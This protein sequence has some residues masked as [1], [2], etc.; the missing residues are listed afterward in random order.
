MSLY[1]IK[2]G[3]E[4]RFARSFGCVIE[5]NGSR[6]AEVGFLNPSKMFNDYDRPRDVEITS[7]FSDDFMDD[8]SFTMLKNHLIAC[9]PMQIGYTRISAD[10]FLDRATGGRI[11]V[12]ET[13]ACGQIRMDSMDFARFR[14]PYQ[15]QNN[16]VEM[17]TDFVLSWMSKLSVMVN[18]GHRIAITL[19]P[20]R[21]I[22]ISG[23]FQKDHDD[24]IVR[25]ADYNA[26]KR[27]RY[28]LLF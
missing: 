9:G 12:Q 18:A 26:E 13:D 20:K 14:N 17:M 4:D 6:S 7:V 21:P 22:K 8:N 3:K 28:A 23:R 2:Y 10:D 15:Q 19:F 27:K 16:M 24:M 1:E 25:N 11:Y 5:N